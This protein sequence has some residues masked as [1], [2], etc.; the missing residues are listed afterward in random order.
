MLPEANVV[1][2]RG[3][4]RN[5]QETVLIMANWFCDFRISDLKSWAADDCV[6]EASILTDNTKVAH[7]YP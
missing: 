1:R 5:L 6:E 3:T 7:Y 4:I 2:K